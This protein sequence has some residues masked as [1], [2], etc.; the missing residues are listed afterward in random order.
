MHL[1]GNHEF[2]TFRRTLGAIVTHADG[3]RRSTKTA[4]TRWMHAHLRLVTEPYDDRD[5]LGRLERNV[6]AEL[7]PPLNLQHMKPTPVRRRLKQLRRTIT[8]Q[9]N[10]AES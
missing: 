8:H 2:S 5:A 3:I 10:G 1:G 6:L 9:S 7:D 4:L